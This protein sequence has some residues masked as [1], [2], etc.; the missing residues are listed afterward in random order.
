MAT[1]TIADL[2]KVYLNGL[3]KPLMRNSL[4][5]D[6]LVEEQSPQN[7][8]VVIEDVIQNYRQIYRHC[9]P[10]ISVG[11]VYTPIYLLV[12]VLSPR[13]HPVMIKVIIYNY[14]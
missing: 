11:T 4:G 2:R 9:I 1:T 10:H 5:T 14:T 13:D 7:H 3:Q 8:T 6:W 12:E